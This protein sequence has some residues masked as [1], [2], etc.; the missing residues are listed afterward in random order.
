ME[1]LA[2]ITTP[3]VTNCLSTAGSA[4]GLSRSDV[5]SM[6]LNAS[7]AGSSAFGIIEC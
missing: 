5:A 4:E 1:D 3:A 6:S 2:T 7:A